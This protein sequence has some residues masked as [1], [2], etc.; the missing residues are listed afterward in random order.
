MTKLSQNTQMPKSHKSP[1]SSVRC[2]I[3]LIK[4]LK[5]DLK[6]NIKRT[7]KSLQKKKLNILKNTARLRKRKRKN[8]PR[9]DRWSTIYIFE[10]LTFPNTYFCE[11]PKRISPKIGRTRETALLEIY[12]RQK[13][14]KK[15]FFWKGNWI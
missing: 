8:T 1:K 15:R 11:K 12:R 13:R 3:T 14:I 5:T 9:N 6:S 2:G 10:F 7:R 4:P